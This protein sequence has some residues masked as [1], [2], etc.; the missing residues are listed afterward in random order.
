MNISLIAIFLVIFLSRFSFAAEESIKLNAD[1]TKTIESL[2][3][4]F[5]GMIKQ[6]Q[7]KDGN[8]LIMYRVV[9]DPETYA[10]QEIVGMRVSV[11]QKGIILSIDP[12]LQSKPIPSEYEII[13]QVSK[14]ATFDDILD[15]CDYK[16][17]S[18]V[19]R[20]AVLISWARGVL[21]SKNNGAM[22]LKKDSEYPN[23]LKK[24]FPAPYEKINVKL[25]VEGGVS[26]GLEDFANAVIDYGREVSE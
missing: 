1:I 25:P 17:I 14:A 15:R 8:I 24:D 6:T 16:N 11:N 5:K 18:E 2:D 20:L 4:K 9:S 22:T 12:M 19:S 7:S 10:R 13:D 21:I 3:N 23:L 26:K